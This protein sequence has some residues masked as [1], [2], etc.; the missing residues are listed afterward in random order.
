MTGK[1]SNYHVKVLAFYSNSLINEITSESNNKETD[2]VE[3]KK[4]FRIMYA[5]TQRKTHSKC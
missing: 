2:P 3:I 4:S 1:T 5:A